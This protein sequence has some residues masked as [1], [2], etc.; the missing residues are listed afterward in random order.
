MFYLVGGSMNKKKKILLVGLGLVFTLVLSLNFVGFF[1]NEKINIQNVLSNEYYS[2]LPDEAKNYIQEVYEETGVVFLTEKNKKV[3]SPYL[4]PDYVKYL[5]EGVASKSGYI[6][7][8][9]ATDIDFASLGA[10]SDELPSKYDLRNVDGVSYITSMK[11]QGDFGLCW[12]FAA[13]GAL[14]SKILKEGLY[15]GSGELDLSERQIDYATAPID[16]ASD[17]GKNPYFINNYQE[18]SLGG[19][20]D[21]I[22]YMNAILA[23]VSPIYEKDWNHDY[24]FTG[25][26][27]P[28]EIYNNENVYYDVDGVYYLSDVESPDD[29][30]IN[31]MK[32]LIMKNGALSVGVPVNGIPKIRYNVNGQES[33][34]IKGTNYNTLYYRPKEYSYPNGH[35][36]MII[37]WDDNYNHNI[38]S[39]TSTPFVE[40]AKYSSE[41]GSYSCSNGTLKT[42]NG[43]WIAKNSY[44]SDNKEAYFYLA[45]ESHNLS[46]TI[47][48][49]VGVKEWDNVYYKGH[50]DYYD[51]SI[52]YQKINSSEKIDKIKFTTMSSNTTATIKVSVDE[53]DNYIEVGQVKITYPGLYSLDLSSKNI[54]LDGET[55]GIKVIVSDYVSHSSNVASVFTSN[56][57][58]DVEIVMEDAKVEQS[59]IYQ[60]LIEE[61]NIVVIDGLT[62]NLNTQKQILYKVF[63]SNQNDVTSKFTF[64]RNYSVSNHINTLIGFN[65]DVSKGTYVVKAYV[66]NVLYDDFLLNVDTYFEN[67]NGDG[68]SNNPYIIK[69][70]IQ[71]DMIRTVGDA[72]YKLGNNIDLSYDTSNPAGLFYNDG[73]GW[74]PIDLSQNSKIRFNGGFDGNNYQINGIFINRPNE[75][76]VGLF[77]IIEGG[78]NFADVYVKNL[79][80]T[81]PNITGKKYVGG[82]IGYAHAVT[83]ERCMTLENLSVKYGTIKGISYVGGV[84]GGARMGTR[85]TGYC[86][87]DGK[88]RHTVDSLYNSSTVQAENYS[89]GNIGVFDGMYYN[90]SPSYI[91]NIQNSG[92]IISSDI[93]SGLI[94]MV[95]EIEDNSITINNGINTGKVESVNKYSLIGGFK[96]S[97]TG[98][99]NLNNMYYINGNAYPE[100]TG[101]ESNNVSKKTITE[102]KND[103]NYTNWE[104][105]NIKTVNNVKRIPV[106]TFVDFDYT[107]LNKNT[108]ESGENIYSLVLPKHTAVENITYEI[109]DSSIAEISDDGKII[110]LK[111]GETSIKIL[112]NYDGYEGSVT[113][114]ISEKMSSI[115]VNDYVIDGEYLRNISENTTINRYIS[116]FSITNDYKIKLFDLN[117]E[118]LANNSIVYTGSL[119]KIYL[120][121]ELHKTYIN[122]VLGD[123]TGDGLIKMNDIMKLASYII[124]NNVMTEFYYIEAGDFT[125]D[126]DIRMNDVMKLAT[127]ALGGEE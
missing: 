124:D 100:V 123:V 84:I 92:K 115:N 109:L 95:N 74:E 12:D 73:K 25:K 44:G 14:E 31:N 13:T 99:L 61:D 102:L 53:S 3:G 81:N 68:T 24:S 41:T 26:L 70:A 66:D 118:E 45:Y 56:K 107:S 37:G 125:N 116:N 33:S 94:G 15:I 19:F 88:N 32:N 50:I 108:I 71:L 60:G 105:W 46:Y 47:F 29:N 86:V 98:K 110:P 80:L 79:T 111:Q 22:P 11:D 93:A 89:A 40:D 83:N 34:L 106:L 122:I 42:I 72:F 104:K 49:D 112:S 65:S 23:G 103:S 64:Y 54:V 67:V 8:S 126:S 75:D 78:S 85:L 76:Y 38:C 17:I 35:E 52:I 43:A 97:N 120:N 90:N 114:K 18:R 6:P 27:P 63:D 10:V 55:F 62:R 5:A 96:Q 7:A 69:N 4:N 57:D 59:F 82:I 21:T 30:F 117:D 1:S 2:Y 91:N 48:Y 113:L 121:D 87:A 77:G 16:K 51:R 119:T 20:G 58:D 36:V 9:T 101:V 28:I 39:N 127:Y